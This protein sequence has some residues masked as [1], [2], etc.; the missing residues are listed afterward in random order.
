MKGVRRSEVSGK[1][2]LRK[3]TFMLKPE[4]EI[5]FRQA[6]RTDTNSW[7]EGTA[8]TKAVAYMSS[9]Y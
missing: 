4:R 8:Y 3:I 9:K 5:S 7:A 2:S 6:K 1:P